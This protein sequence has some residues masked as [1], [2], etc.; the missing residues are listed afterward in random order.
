MAEQNISLSVPMALWKHINGD[1][2]ADYLAVSRKDGSVE[3]YINGGGPDTG[4]NAAKVVW[5]PHGKIGTGVGTSEKGVQFADLNGNGRAE[6]I[7]VS[8]ATSAVNVWS[9]GG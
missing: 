1:G 6:F 7:D 8:F 2:R 4:S 9:N 5:Y 3:A